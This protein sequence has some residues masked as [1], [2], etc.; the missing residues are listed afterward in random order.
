[1]PWGFGLE[2]IGVPTVVWHGERDP[3]IPRAVA[4]YAIRTIPTCTGQI[5]PEEGHMLVHS[6]APA[7]LESVVKAPG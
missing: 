7:I 2:D 4:D 1:L 6:H 3:T 5:L